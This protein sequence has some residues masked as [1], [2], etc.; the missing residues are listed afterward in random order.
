MAGKLET[1]DVQKERNGEISPS[2]EQQPTSKR[3]SRSP[4]G[5]MEDISG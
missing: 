5:N 3:E 2:V 1:N 4:V